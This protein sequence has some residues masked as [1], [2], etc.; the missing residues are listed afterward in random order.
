MVSKKVLI[1][2]N[3]DISSNKDVMTGMHAAMED[4]RPQN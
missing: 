1:P 4:L 2:T 3:T